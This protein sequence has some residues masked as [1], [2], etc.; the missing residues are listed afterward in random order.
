MDEVRV[1]QWV[2]IIS[3]NLCK[4]SF[5]NENNFCFSMRVILVIVASALGFIIVGMSHS[6]TMTVIGVACTSF[7]SGLGESSLISY[8]VFFD[9]K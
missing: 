4:D 7:A 3:V 2:V 5:L 8:T 6:L 9:D 1:L